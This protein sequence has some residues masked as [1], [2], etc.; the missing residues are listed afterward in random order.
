M[1]DLLKHEHAGKSFDKINDDDDKFDVIC[2]LND[3]LL[4]RIVSRTESWL[5]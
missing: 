3:T 2:D 5:A 1:S 4:D